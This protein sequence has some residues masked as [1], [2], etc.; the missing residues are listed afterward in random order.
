MTTAHQ[1]RSAA[2]R[3]ALADF[4]PA[5]DQLRAAAPR[6]D[7]ERLHPFEEV[8][9]LAAL[10]LGAVRLPVS[11]GGR[12]LSLSELYDLLIEVGAAD[13][14]IPQALRQHYFRVELALLAP[15]SEDRVRDLEAIASGTLYGNGT[16]EASDVSIGRINTV[17]RRVGETPDGVGEYR[18][19]GKKFYSTG[20]LYSQFIPVSAVDDDGEAVVVIVPADRAGVSILDDWP[21]FGQK[22]T[23]SGTTLFDDVLVTES[24]VLRRGA[25]ETHHGMGF[26]QLILLA[27]LAGIARGAANDVVDL[28]RE[29]RRVYSA[30]SGDLPR[31]DPLIQEAVGRAEAAAVTA[32][33]LVLSAAGVLEEAWDSWA[34]PSADPAETSALF[35]HAD[36]VVSAAQVSLTPLVLEQTSHLFDALGASAT[37]VTVALDR[38]WRNARTVGS[39]NPWIYKARQVGDYVLNGTLPPIFVA[40]AD[41]G[42]HASASPVGASA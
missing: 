18:L 40:G 13:S 20:N 31:H 6:N 4:A 34:D 24:E 38:H 11:A 19:T 5:L 22:L 7:V 39:H 30:G 8:R 33:A 21:G 41:V 16:S 36:I 12:G 9:A 25:P 37:H 17:L 10:G 14:N 3:A 1:G 26:H 42:V 28:V 15:P 35:A 32:R 23:A 29:R 2:L 27:T